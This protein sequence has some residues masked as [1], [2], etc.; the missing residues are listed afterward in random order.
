LKNIKEKLRKR[1]KRKGMIENEK[2]QVPSSSTFKIERE[3]ERKGRRGKR[4]G[5][6]N[7]EREGKR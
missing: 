4:R 5:E 2:R 6:E 7:E 3:V 1:D